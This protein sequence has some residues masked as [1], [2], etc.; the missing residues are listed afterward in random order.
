[1]FVSSEQR[2]RHRFVDTSI[3]DAQRVFQDPFF[4]QLLIKGVATPE[5][6]HTL[7]RAAFVPNVRHGE[8]RIPRQYRYKDSTPVLAVMP[9][10]EVRLSRDFATLTPTQLD[11]ARRTV[12]PW[13]PHELTVEELLD[14]LQK[15]SADRMNKTPIH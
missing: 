5:I 12:K 13:N 8:V 10:E 3:E 6:L 1:M 15:V 11:H 9:D 7:G 2:A 4:D 14:I